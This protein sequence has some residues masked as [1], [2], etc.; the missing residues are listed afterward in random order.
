MLFVTYAFCLNKIK[1][2]EYKKTKGREN[3][4][5]RG[6]RWIRTQRKDIPVFIPVSPKPICRDRTRYDALA[7]KALVRAARAARLAAAF[8]S[9]AFFSS[10]SRFR[11]ASS[12]LS[13][14]PRFLAAF[15]QMNNKTTN[16]NKRRHHE[17]KSITKR[18][19]NEDGG[20]RK[21]QEKKTA[22]KQIEPMWF[23]NDSFGWDLVPPS[24]SAH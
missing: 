20:C 21:E 1:R 23:L 18:K 11:R 24:A 6:P 9:D 2:K 15:W 14:A 5:I 22:G 3:E 17:L 10:A 7:S 4:T 19:E 13:F 8:S 12:P 16:E